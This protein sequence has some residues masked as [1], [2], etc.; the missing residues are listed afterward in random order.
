MLL[1]CRKPP[2]DEEDDCQNAGA[3]PDSSHTPAN[4]AVIQNQPG[5][6]EMVVMDSSSNIPAVPANLTA[7]AHSSP[8]EQL[9][10][11]TVP[12]A[13]SRP[14]SENAHL[15]SPQ[16]SSQNVDLPST[17]LL[18]PDEM[19]MLQEYQRLTGKSAIVSAMVAEPLSGTA[20][21]SVSF[22]YPIPSTPPPQSRNSVTPNTSSIQRP[23]SHQPHLHVNARP[24][25]LSATLDP[26]LNVAPGLLSPSLS[27]TSSCLSPSPPQHTITKSKPPDLPTSI[28]NAPEP[29][30]ETDT[31]SKI[32]QPTNTVQS[33]TAERMFRGELANWWWDA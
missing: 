27:S 20:H 22:V 26:L 4:S 19:Q 9:K 32:G 11:S 6:I 12:H 16:P 24:S 2:A 23:S 5:S 21:N 10:P 7:S 3:K 1:Y 13:T 33:N 25:Q 18:S 8:L 30:L 29:Y 15:A 14:P 31:Q 28:N 17:N